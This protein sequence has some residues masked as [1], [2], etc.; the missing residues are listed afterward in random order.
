MEC[1]YNGQVVTTRHY[2][3]ILYRFNYQRPIFLLYNRL[4]S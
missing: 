4:P 3:S 1:Y 2:P